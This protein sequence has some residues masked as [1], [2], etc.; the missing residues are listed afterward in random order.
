MISVVMSGGSGS[1]LWPLSRS[2]YPKQ[3]VSLFG[4]SLFFKTLERLE[5][6][7]SIWVVGAHSQRVLAEKCLKQMKSNSFAIYEPVGR[8]TAPV[9]ALI[10]HLLSL[11]GKEDEIVGVFP[12]DHL[13]ERVQVMHEALRL[14]EREAQNDKIVTLG[15]LPT[16]PATGFG[17]IETSEKMKVSE[18]S[19]SLK[20]SAVNQFFEKP[21]LDVAKTFY[22]SSQHFWNAGIFVFKVSFMKAL[23]K[24][25]QPD[26]WE[27]LTGLKEDLSNIGEIYNKVPSDSI[28]YAIMEKLTDKDLRCIPVDMGWSDVGS[29]EAVA[30]IGV[31]DVD[32]KVEVNSRGNFVCSH[33]DKTYC[34][35]GM[36]DMIL[37]DTQ[38]ALLIS[39]KAQ[40]QKVKD[41]VEKVKLLQNELTVSH[42]FEER[43]WGYF[44]VLRDAEQFKSKII[45]VDGGQQ[46][47]YQMHNK[48]EEHWLILRG[49]GEVV[50]NDKVVSVETGDYIH[51]PLKAKHRIRNT[52]AEPIEFIE[53]QL[54]EYFGEDDIV[55]FEDDYNRT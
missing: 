42:K 23:F 9:V 53:I 2:K 34:F 29:W 3:F 18:D 44:E 1:R 31:E 17:Y 4:E 8:N 37:V 47:S 41:V 28:D 19:K 38:D 36:E 51:V 13:V 40:T 50:L 48:R 49:K 45:R 46:L 12:A 21:E 14:A 39:D 52:G 16:Y 10:C 43:P 22:Q 11:K 25:Y 5:P 54:G 33:L 26:L 20:A 35:V 30:D 7:G 32:N 6:M 27:V 55:R 15:I 24:K